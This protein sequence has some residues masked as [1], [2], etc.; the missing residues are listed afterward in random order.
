MPPSLSLPRKGGEDVSNGI[1]RMCHAPI[2]RGLPS[3][4]AGEGFAPW[5]AE[6]G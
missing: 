3:T 1:W 5:R 4:L 2:F 6:R